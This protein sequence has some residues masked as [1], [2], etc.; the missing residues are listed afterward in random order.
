[1]YI[2]QHNN[3]NKIDTHT[4][5]HECSTVICAMIYKNEQNKYTLYN[6]IT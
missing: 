3:I 2:F 4:H 1:M 5:T 6:Q